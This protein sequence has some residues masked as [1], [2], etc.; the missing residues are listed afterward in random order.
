M[1]RTRYFGDDIFCW[2]FV[3][4]NS[5]CKSN[6]EICLRDCKD[7]QFRLCHININWAKSTD[8]RI[9]K[10]YLF[11]E[12]WSVSWKHSHLFLQNFDEVRLEIYIFS[13]AISF[14]WLKSVLAR[15]WK[16]FFFLSLGK[17]VCVL[18]RFAFPG[19]IDVFL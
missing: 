11:L 7:K 10:K 9:I 1:I 4:Y 14:S 15:F 16:T 8:E 2:H 13:Y 12:V 18:I 5:W 6:F 3:Q 17:I 19:E